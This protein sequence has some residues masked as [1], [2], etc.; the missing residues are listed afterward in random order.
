MASWAFCCSW[1]FL[2]A[3]CF[4]SSALFLAAILSRRS[5]SFLAF[6]SRSFCS[7]S[8]SSHCGHAR[9]EA[10]Q[11]PLPGIGLLA[12]TFSACSAAFFLASSASL[13]SL[14][15][16]SS[17]SRLT[18]SMSALMS[19]SLWCILVASPRAMATRS[20]RR[21]SAAILTS[22]LELTRSLVSLSSSLLRSSNLA[23]RCSEAIPLSRAARAD[24]P[25]DLISGLESRTHASSSGTRSGA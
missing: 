18:R 12:A 2:S 21:C 4:S 25:Y 14:S 9:H 19:S 5:C 22:S 1:N 20:V 10:S 17:A 7:S 23:L 15:F 24:A 8:A 16:F 3:W 11:N 6:S 13:A